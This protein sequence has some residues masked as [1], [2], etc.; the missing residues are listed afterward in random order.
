MPPPV[1]QNA[2]VPSGIHC[3]RC[4]PL[5]LIVPYPSKSIIK[6][7]PEGICSEGFQL[8]LQKPTIFEG[9]GFTSPPVPLLQTAE[10]ELRV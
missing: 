2:S 6:L 9:S 7:D 5:Q 4:L 3:G 1:L 8:F 10:Q